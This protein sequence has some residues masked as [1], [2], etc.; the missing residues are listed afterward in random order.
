MRKSSQASSQHGLYLSWSLNFKCISA[1]TAANKLCQA[2][3]APSEGTCRN[4]HNTQKH[5]SSSTIPTNTHLRSCGADDQLIRQPRAGPASPPQLPAQIHTPRNIC[6]RS[7]C[8]ASC[9]S[10]VEIRLT[11]HAFGNRPR[12][13][14]QHGLRLSSSLPLKLHQRSP[15]CKQALSSLQCA[16]KRHMQDSHNTQKHKKGRETQATSK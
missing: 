16:I 8:S 9:V 5:A 10:S 3:N 14:A 7:L 11:Y 2:C 6:H 4:R 12:H 1:A 15:C 13:R